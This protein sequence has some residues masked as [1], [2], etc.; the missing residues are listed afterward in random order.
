MRALQSSRDVSGRPHDAGPLARAASGRCE[1][2]IGALL[3]LV[4]PRRL[5][6]AP[7]LAAQAGWGVAVQGRTFACIVYEINPKYVVGR[8]IL[9][10]GDWSRERSRK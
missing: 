1:N 8:A 9:A 5:L 4:D 2:F 6:Q 3:G 7:W 10:G